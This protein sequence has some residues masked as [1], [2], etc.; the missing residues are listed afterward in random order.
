MRTRNK[1]ALGIAAAALAALVVWAL[2][3]QPALVETAKVARGPFEQTVSDDG[4]TRV[5]E[6]YV[7]SAPLAGRVD[8]IGLKAGDPVEEGQVVAVL[9]PSMPAFLDARTVRELE[10]RVGA[11]ESQRLRAAA[12]V[13]KAAAQVAQA[14]SDVER[15]RLLSDEGY[16]S[17]NA[18]E[19]ARLA[20][21]T[22]E[23]GREAA[24]FAEHAA[25]HDVEQARAALVRYRAESAGKIVGARWEVK[26]PI[27]GSVLKV[28]QESE[29]VVPLG[30]PLIEVADPRSLEAVVDVLSEEGVAIRPGMPARIE[31]GSGVPPLAARVRRIEPAAFTKVSALGVE[32][33]RVNVVLDFAEPLDKVQTIG[34]GFRVEAHIV[35]FRAQDAVKAPVGALFRRGKDWAVF[36]LEGGRA[37][38]RPVKLARRNGS[39]AMIE[40]GLEPGET[41]VVYPSDALEDGTRVKLQPN[42]GARP[43]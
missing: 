12:E 37:L 43:G 22:A 41:V 3:P 31:L 32:E 9:T 35:T 2:R 8:R 16:I 42:G 24:G 25:V 7:V 11:A 14:R 30:A 26:S 13:Q 5:R 29:G 34:D 39:E 38:L 21:I 23:K 28:V 36:V 10:A 19:Q 40:Q 27:K 4:K 20:L 15:A 18:L 1:I 6:R 17:T 33:Q